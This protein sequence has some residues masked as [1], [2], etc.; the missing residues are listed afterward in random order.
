VIET[1][2]AGE[3]F[4]K[5]SPAHFLSAIYLDALDIEKPY[6]SVVSVAQCVAKG[7]G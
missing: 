7:V 1:G 5:S 2:A 6:F 4:P 3:D